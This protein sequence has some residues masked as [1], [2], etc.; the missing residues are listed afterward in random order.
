MSQKS[1][2]TR[3]L[4]ACTR[5]LSAA[6]VVAFG[7]VRRLPSR[8]P[9]RRVT[10]R[11]DNNRWQVSS[12]SARAVRLNLDAKGLPVGLSSPTRVNRQVFPTAAPPTFSAS[13]TPSP[14]RSTFR[15][16]EQKA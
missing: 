3:A 7:L 11:H 1:S 10:Q 13:L 14:P 6:V 16:A 2:G 5:V 4:I 9:E 8:S 15:K 12:A